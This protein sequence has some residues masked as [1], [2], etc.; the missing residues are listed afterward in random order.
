MSPHIDWAVGVPYSSEDV[1]IDEFTAQCAVRRWHLAGGGQE[2][3]ACKGV[4][5]S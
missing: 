3:V 1:S 5:L 4:F 2:R